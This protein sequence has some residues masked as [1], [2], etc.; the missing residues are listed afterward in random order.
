MS[1]SFGEPLTKLRAVPIHDSGEPLL[2]PCGLSQRVQFADKHPR[3]P[4]MQRTPRVRKRVAEMLAQ[5]ADSLPDGIDLVIIEG[6]RPIAQQRFMYE[7]IKADFAK[8]H[9]EWNKATLHRVVNTLSA[10]P[11]D[12]CPP[13][14]STGGAVDVGL[15]RIAD[16]D[17]LDMT[18]PFGMDETSAPADFYGIS[19]QAKA[20]R[21]TLFQSLENAGLTNYRG[22]WWHWSYGDSGWALRVGAKEALYGR[23]PEAAE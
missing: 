8:R 2:D 16:G 9:P 18:S 6:F 20:N 21:N 22:E 10:P 7:E 14:H 19:D 1:R 5:A 13:P 12:V 3:F 15:I 17:W 4:D 11:D 23:L